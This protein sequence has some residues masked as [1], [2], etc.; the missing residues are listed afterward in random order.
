[1]WDK[2]TIPMKERG[3]LADREEQEQ[4]FNSFLEGSLMTEE[5]E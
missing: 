5:Y 4:L 3:N 1:V 2:V